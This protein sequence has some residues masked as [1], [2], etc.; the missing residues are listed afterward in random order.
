MRT[1]L[2]IRHFESGLTDHSIINAHIFEFGIMAS[3]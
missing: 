3:F 1:N 2:E